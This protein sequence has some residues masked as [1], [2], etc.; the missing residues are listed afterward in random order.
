MELRL[1]RW[2]SKAIAGLGLPL[3]LLRSGFLEAPR[4]VWHSK[5]TAWMKRS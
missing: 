5:R 2:L 4:S 1:R 3:Q